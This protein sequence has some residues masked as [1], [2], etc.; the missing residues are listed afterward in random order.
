MPLLRLREIEKSDLDR[1]S[2]EIQ[3]KELAARAQGEE[4]LRIENTKLKQ[5]ID[6]LNVPPLPRS[7]NS[8]TSA[9]ASPPVAASSTTSTSRRSLSCNLATLSTPNSAARL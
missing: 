3:I 6:R 4:Q 2:Y 5:F 8:R 1:H 7:R 9:S